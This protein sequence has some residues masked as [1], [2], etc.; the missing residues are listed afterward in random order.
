[1]RMNR[2]WI[3][4]LEKESGISIYFVKSDGETEDY[5]YNTLGILEDGEDGTVTARAEHP[6]GEDF[7][8]SDYSFCV[9]GE[10]GLERFEVVHV[11]K[12]P[13]KDYVSRTVHVRKMV[14]GV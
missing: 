3:W 10:G 7:Y 5:L 12:G 9:D 11:V 14:G 13:A 2:S 1:M 8:V 6:C 4:R